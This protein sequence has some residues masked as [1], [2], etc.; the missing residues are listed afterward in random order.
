[1]KL[2]SLLLTVAGA[3]IYAT[4][5]AQIYD[6]T[7]GYLRNSSFD[8]YFDYT[9]SDEGNIVPTSN[10]V[11]AG[12]TL[13]TPTTN[14]AGV[15]ATVEIGTKTTINGSAV[16]A[17]GYDGETE[18]G[19]AAFCIKSTATYTLSQEVTLPPGTYTIVNASLNTTN[20]E[21]VTSQLK[22][23]PKKGIVSSTTRLFP[24]NEWKT[25][26][27]T[28]TIEE[29][30]DGQIYTGFSTTKAASTVVFMDWIK[31]Y[32]DT[33]LGDADF[34]VKRNK[35]ATLLETATGLYGDGEGVSAAELKDAIDKA[36]AVADNAEA[37]LLDLN[38]ASLSL[39]TAINN[40]SWAQKVTINADSRYLRGATMA[41]TRMTVTGV[42]TSQIAAKG[43]VYSKSPMPTIAD[44]ANEEELSKNGT[45]FW[46]KNLEPGTQYYFRPFVKS[47]DGSVAY[48]EQKMFYTIPKGTISYEV[49]SGG[50]DEQYNRI[51][52][53]TIEAVNYWNNLTSIKDVRISAGFVDGVPTA[54]C[55]Y[56]GWIRVGSNSAYQATGTLLHEMLHGVGVIPWAGGQWSQ[57]TLRKSKQSAQGGTFGSGDWLGDRATAVAQFW[58]N[59]TT[60]VLHGDYQHMWPF[61]IN[62]AN[63]DTHAV[64]L[65]LSNGLMIQALAE[66]GLETS[67]KHHGAP[68][69]AKEVETGVKYYL[70]AESEDCGR[71]T[72]YLT[73]S[74]VNRLAMKEMTA[75]EAALNDSAAWYVSFNPKN[76][77]Y[78]LTNAATGNRMSYD[79]SA[80]AFRSTSSTA[81][82][83][84]YDLQMMRGRVD[85][86][87]NKLRGYWILHPELNNWTPACLTAGTTISSTG[88]NLANDG[89]GLLQRWLI[90]SEEELPLVD[91]ETL[92]IDF[93]GI[94]TSDKVATVGVYSINGAQLRK[95]NSTEGLAKG[96]YIVGGKKVVVR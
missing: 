10:S 83:Y 77:Y 8:T 36:K 73:E 4:A 37:T 84:N 23:R 53:A 38:D 78:Q 22:W 76:Q 28:F 87:E 9:A 67:Y 5:S 82:N 29:T 49:R 79:T 12:W 91:A 93:A 52:N 25:D 94:E 85:V 31:L 11:P 60:D 68:Y 3:G 41:F 56:G 33:P 89:N 40:Y 15:L 90:L 88:L 35:L 71:L 44:Q 58:N 2:K 13:I 17:Q 96:I 20:Q 51:K 16:P 24:E 69:Y 57:F 19:L 54:D 48:G 61:G 6:I 32:R 72:K 92:G 75:S 66:D 63:E 95:T 42:T 46:K 14:K 65:Y 50:T 21:A 45:I 30:A 27:I 62:G 74:K 81:S 34:T 55:S 39:N 18:G 70:K 26:T 86:T 64:E 80:K 1:M 43:F 59:N 7:E 47:T